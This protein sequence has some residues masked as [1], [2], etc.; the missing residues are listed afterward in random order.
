MIEI[1]DCDRTMSQ[2]YSNDGGWE[3]KPKEQ[4]IE[5]ESSYDFSST[6][7]ALWHTT[8]LS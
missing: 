7:L 8:G 2:P 5:A 3:Q 6:Q 4:N 1:L